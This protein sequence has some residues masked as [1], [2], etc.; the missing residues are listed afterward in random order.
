MNQS[1]FNDQMTHSSVLSYVTSNFFSL[2][3][4]DYGIRKASCW[5][6]TNIS[7]LKYRKYGFHGPYHLDVIKYS[8][9]NPFQQRDTEGRNR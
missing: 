7:A 2:K 3:Y 1:L 9:Q 6:G 8:L 4:G 5:L